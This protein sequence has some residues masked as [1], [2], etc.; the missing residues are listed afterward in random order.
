MLI[1]NIW[2]ACSETWSLTSRLSRCSFYMLP[3]CNH[4]QLIV[5]YVG[6][7]KSQ[8]DFLQRWHPVTVQRSE[9]VSSLG[10]SIFLKCWWRQTARLDFTHMQ[11]WDWKN[12]TLKEATQ[13][14][15][16]CAVSWNI[17]YRLIKY[18]V[19]FAMNPRITTRRTLSNIYF[20]GSATVFCI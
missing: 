10:R 7:K 9:S 12:E 18:R 14:F 20:G 3:L 17:S 19:S 1:C 6:G 4:L 13:Y 11:Q 16:Q 15:H 2:W 8:T 5:E